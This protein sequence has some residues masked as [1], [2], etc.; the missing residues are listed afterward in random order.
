MANFTSVSSQLPTGVVRSLLTFNITLSFTASLGNVL[1]LWT[2][3]KV[4]SL[5]S[6]TKFLFECLATTDLCVGLFSQPLFVA[7]LILHIDLSNTNLDILFYVEEILYISSYVL[8]GV[9]VLTSTAISVDR[10]LVLLLRLRYT[11][12]VTL[13]RAQ[14]VL[15]ICWV[16][17][18]SCGLVRV[19]SLTVSEIVVFVAGLA[20]LITSVFCY[21]KIHLI[22]LRNRA[23]VED[24]LGGRQS[25]K[26]EVGTRATTGARRV[27]EEEE[28]EKEEEEKEAGAKLDGVGVTTGAGRAVEEEEEEEEARAEENRVGV[29][30]GAGKAVKEEEEEEKE[31]AG[32]REI[33]V[34]KTRRTGRT[35]EQEE[36]KEEKEAGSTVKATEKSSEETRKA[37]NVS[38][39]RRTQ[40]GVR[41]NIVQYKKIVSSI[42]WLQL[43]LVACYA[44]FIIV[45]LLRYK[46]LSGTTI[47]AL[48]LFTATLI[49]LNASLN[50]FLYCWKIREPVTK[51]LFESLATTDLCVGL[52]SQPLFVAVLILHIDL[53]NTNLDILCNVEKIVYISS[54]VLCGVSGLTSTVISVDRLLVLFLKLRYRQIV[55][56]KRAQA[57]ILLCWVLAVSCGL[58]RVW[59]QTVSETAAFVTGLASL[60]TSVFCYVKIH[61]RLQ[62]NR[63]EVEDSTREGQPNKGEG[64][65]ERATTGAGRI[66]E[67][68]EE[69]EEAGRREDGVRLTTKAGRTAREVEEGGTRVGATE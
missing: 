64:V 46:V 27:A 1:I 13:R 69:E 19:W 41:L 49:Y 25:N 10:L 50:P 20:S 12:I 4:S 37:I 54:F 14:A 24:S 36:E 6:V 16:L 68:E 45:S 53:S 9:S 21:V 33:G 55:T 58:V 26:R 65:G 23:E 7:V 61:L 35:A 66:A 2:L 62:W 40:Q 28:E 51:L 57:V 48:W 31:E 8:C 18:V 17:A 5:H 59:S 32:A 29:T 56:L 47:D 30:T 52:F 22:L 43:T 11:Q 60:V 3:Y 67:E 34:G 39:K 42:F 63:A 44:P 15:L 38:P